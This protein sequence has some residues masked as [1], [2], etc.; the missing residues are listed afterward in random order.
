MGKALA[1]FSLDVD[2]S[3][4]PEVGARDPV[5]GELQARYGWLRP[6]C[7][8]SPYEAAVNFVVGQRISMRQ[9]RA[10]RARMARE[11]GDP[12]EL[13]NGIASADRPPDVAHDEAPDV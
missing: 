13:E 3:G 5:V 11:L 7:F 9:A 1:T 6:V 2:A 8:H 4:F 12:V 10:V